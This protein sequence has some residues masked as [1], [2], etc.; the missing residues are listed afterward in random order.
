MSPAV[1]LGRMASLPR[2]GIAVGAILLVLGVVFAGIGQYQ[3]ATD[4]CVSGTY[5]SVDETPSPDEDPVAFESLSPVEQRALTDALEGNASPLRSYDGRVDVPRYVRYR[6]ATYEA[7]EGSLDCGPE[8][9][10]LKV[11]GGAGLILG[12]LI[13]VISYVALR[14]RDD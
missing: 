10:V 4:P 5:L 2:A 9:L 7:V 11:V 14:V 6:N 1:A 12:A 13:V 8:G 3:A